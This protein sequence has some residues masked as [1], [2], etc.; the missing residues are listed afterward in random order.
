MAPNK[1]NNSGKLDSGD[2]WK[3]DRE[4]EKGKN[5]KE[6]KNIQITLHCLSVMKGVYNKIF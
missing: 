5:E 3:R 1:V 6:R 4:F 2:E